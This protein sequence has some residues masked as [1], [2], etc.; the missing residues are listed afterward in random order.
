MNDQSVILSNSGHH[1]VDDASAV[2]SPK[3]KSKKS[4][5]SSSSSSS[6]PKAKTVCSP[7]EGSLNS[8]TKEQL[9]GLCAHFFQSV[10]PDLQQEFENAMPPPDLHEIM[11]ELDTLQKQYNKLFPNNKFVFDNNSY[12]RVK[13][14]LASF[15]K[16]LVENGDG[17]KDKS[18]WS[19]LLQYVIQALPYALRMPQW[20]DEKNNASR[21][22]AISKMDLFGKCAVKGLLQNDLSIEKWERHRMTLLPHSSYLTNTIDE[23]NKCID[24][25]KKKDAKLE[26][27]TK[28][29]K[30]TNKM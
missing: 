18:A 24:K 2:G 4:K 13:S 11:E 15:K 7:L 20:D 3:I 19:T 28:K 6:K 22:S 5:S 16:A 9:V 14:G 12:N 29:R 25:R 21:V 1:H 8:L 23:L 30:T 27:T 17:F 10:H 26:K